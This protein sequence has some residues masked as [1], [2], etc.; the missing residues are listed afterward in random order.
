MLVISKYLRCIEAELS[1]GTLV[2]TEALTRITRLSRDDTKEVA[3]SFFVFYLTSGFDFYLVHNN[4]VQTARED[5]LRSVTG[6]A[7]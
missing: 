1:P 7:Q 4:Y 5:H 2:V 6:E 3:L